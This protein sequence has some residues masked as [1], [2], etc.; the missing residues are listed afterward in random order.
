MKNHSIKLLSI[1]LGFA[2][3]FGACSKESDTPGNNNNNTGGNNNNN[4][5]NN[6]N[7][8]TVGQQMSYVSMD[9]TR[10]LA[11]YGNYAYVTRQERGF[12]VVDMTNIKSAS[13]VKTIKDLSFGKAWRTFVHGDKLYVACKDDGV[14]I[15]SLSSPSNP[16]K[17]A[18]YKHG[19][20]VQNVFVDDQYMYLIGGS[21]T[22]DGYVSVHNKTDGSLIGV[23]INGSSSGESERG[24]NSIWV[25]GNHIYAGTNKGYLHI[26]DKSNPSSLTL[27]AKYYNPGTAGHEPWL[28]GIYVTG[29][30]AYLAN[31][32]AGT[33]AL[34]VTNP[35]SPVELG[36]FKD[37]TDGPNAYEVVVKDNIAYIANG[38]GGLTVA[39]VTNPANMTLKFEVN[40]SNHTYHDIELFNNNYAVVTDNGLNQGLRIYKVK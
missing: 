37:G 39:D 14:F 24:F 26:I 18:N 11:I 22:A 12:S 25:S 6:N 33:I 23:Y 38:W 34:D 1:L 30:K 31:W 10:H 9:L 27:A 29:N 2:L 7:Q 35:A 15:Y 28:H 19:N 17:L 5:N 21:G 20:Y 40:I 3:I 4:N 13:L 36:V 8:D 16:T 32:G